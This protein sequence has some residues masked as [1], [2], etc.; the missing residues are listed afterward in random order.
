MPKRKKPAVS[1]DSEALSAALS[2]LAVRG[3][4]EA[5][6]A[7]RLRLKGYSAK[8]IE[9]AVKRCREMGYVNDAGFALERAR[10]LMR[11][12]RAVGHRVLADLRR[13]GVDEAVARAALEQASREF[14]EEV[15]FSNILE[16]RFTH[17]SYRTADDLERRRVVS[18]FLRR[19]FSLPQVLSLMNS[20]DYDG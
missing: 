18:Y 20:K 12:G 15:L 5:E 16:R 11:N 13:H 19:G 9:T 10:I 14:D 1:S 6:L 8:N 3:R 2:L 4:S 7:E 17:F